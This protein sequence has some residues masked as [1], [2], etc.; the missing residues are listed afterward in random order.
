LAQSLPVK[1]R[2]DLQNRS[3]LL[4]RSDFDSRLYIGTLQLGLRRDQS[5]QAQLIN[6]L[7][8]KKGY[9]NEKLI[10]GGDLNDDENSKP[11]SIM[12]QHNAA[13]CISYG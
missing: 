10:L 5:V 9:S 11:Y 1:R 8:N 7:L 13:Q 3:F 4:V 12:L 6:D 2:F